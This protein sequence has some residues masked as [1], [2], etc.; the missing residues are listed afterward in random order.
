MEMTIT[1][2]PLTGML[3]WLRQAERQIQEEI[4]RR[5]RGRRS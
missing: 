2:R 5:Q 3:W 1:D 4:A